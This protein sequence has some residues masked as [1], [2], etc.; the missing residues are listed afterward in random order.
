MMNEGKKGFKVRH[1]RKVASIEPTKPRN[2]VAKNAI[3]SGAGAHKDKKK[4]MKQ[5][6]AKHKKSYA[7]G[8]E[9]K[10]QAQLNELN[11]KTKDSYKD[12]AEKQVK[13]LEPH[14]KKGEYKDIAKR[15]IDRRKK[16][17]ARVSEG[18]KGAVAGGV[19][20]AFA[21]PEAI[22]VGMEIGDKVGDMFDEETDTE[23]GMAKQ[24]IITA[25]KLAIKLAEHM[26]PDTQLDAWV[27][28][29]ISLASDYIETVFDFLVNGEQDVDKNVETDEEVAP[30]ITH[31]H[32]HGT[33]KSTSTAMEG[34]KVDRQAKHITKSMMKAHPS[35]S[36]D[37][38]EGAAWAHIK[39]PKKKKKKVKEDAYQIYLDV[40]L[41][42][43]LKK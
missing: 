16:G 32:R 10:F 12:K 38:A 9:E 23:G 37:E 4:A 1:K 13:E 17:L 33:M 18:I 31:Q 26:Q 8:M 21:G 5:G 36:Q 30:G 42:K 39:H 14:A 28:T 29:K 3:N 43:S 27:Q 11:Q 25:A 40:M 20:G 15:A 22:P 6:D 7:E 19:A 24:Q 2:Y 41:E 35:M 34:A